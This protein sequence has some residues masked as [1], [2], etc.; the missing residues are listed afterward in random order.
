MGQ[1]QAL[2]WVGGWVGSVV[3]VVVVVV[4]VVVVVVWDKPCFM[5]KRVDDGAYPTS[6]F[7]S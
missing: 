7:S 3:V 5:A 6:S 2:R 1:G 4:L